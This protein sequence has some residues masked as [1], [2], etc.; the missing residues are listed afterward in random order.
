MVP[1]RRDLDSIHVDGSPLPRS[2]V[3]PVGAALT[4]VLERVGERGGVTVTVEPVVVRPG[5]LGM[6]GAT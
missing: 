1:A 6:G 3:T 5:S 4:A 2:L